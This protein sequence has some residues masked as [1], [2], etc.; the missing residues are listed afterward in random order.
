MPELK[1]MSEFPSNPSTDKLRVLSQI[2]SGNCLLA[3][4][5]KH[6]NDCDSETFRRLCYGANEKSF[7]DEFDDN[8][9]ETETL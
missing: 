7:S 3:I 1:K 9:D 5:E 6:E 4:H 2:S 8:I